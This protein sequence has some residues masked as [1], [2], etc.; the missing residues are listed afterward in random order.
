MFITKE[1]RLFIAI[2]LL[3]LSSIN[4]GDPRNLKKRSKKRRKYRRSSSDDVPSTPAPTSSLPGSPTDSP[5]DFPSVPTS[6]KRFTVVSQEDDFFFVSA[7]TFEGSRIIQNGAVHEPSEIVVDDDSGEVL[8]DI[9][10]PITGSFF[11]QECTVLK[12]N[13]STMITQNICHHN[14]CLADKGCI[15]MM[16]GGTFEFDPF[17]GDKVPNTTGM[18]IG[19]TGSYV[20]WASYQVQI[21]TLSRREDNS[22]KV[23]V[24]EV[25]IQPIEPNN[26]CD[27][28][29]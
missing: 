10:D 22:K 12:S 26:G 16:T 3:A 5:T 21:V 23:S 7:N 15:M 8:S 24:L 13:G 2:T 11:N 25:Q 1:T 4:A 27:I 14:L 20:R 19:G 29:V 9:P 17:A 6:T 18:V 28:L